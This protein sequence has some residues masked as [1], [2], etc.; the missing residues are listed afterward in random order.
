MGLIYQRHKLKLIQS[1]AIPY[2]DPINPKY[3]SRDMLFASFETANKDTL[4]IFICH[5]PSRFGGKLKSMPKRLNA[6]TILSHFI[7][8]LQR[9]TWSP[10]IIMGDFNDS[11]Q[12][13]SMTMLCRNAG[14]KNLMLDL[15]PKLGSHRYKGEWSYLDQIL[16]SA[17]HVKFVKG[18]GVFQA[19]FLLEPQ[20]RLPGMKPKRAFQGPFFTKGYSD[21]LPIYLDWSLTPNPH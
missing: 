14:L 10:F 6:A 16:V 5:W 7:D 20:G 1:K 15:D 4:N 19:P 11:P 2:R 17:G 3:R 12:D 8:S 13:S 9:Q 18:H 21:H